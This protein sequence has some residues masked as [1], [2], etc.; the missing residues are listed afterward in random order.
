MKKSYS[1]DAEKMKA[2][3][4]LYD[5][6][7]GIR[8]RGVAV[9]HPDDVA[10]ATEKVGLSIAESKAYIKFYEKRSKLQAKTAAQLRSA[11]AEQDKAY[12]LNMLQAAEVER[13][14]GD[15]LIHKDDF[16][17]KIEANRENPH[18]TTTFEQLGDLTKDMSIDQKATIAKQIMEGGQK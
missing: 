15:Y 2:E 3:V 1:Y 4:V 5:S 13:S 11:A 18:Q 10:F 14:L 12:T 16:F 8:A 17:R 6:K 7:T 9:C